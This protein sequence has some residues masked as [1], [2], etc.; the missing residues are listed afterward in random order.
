MLLKLIY[1]GFIIIIIIIFQVKRNE[2]F[3]KILRFKFQ[4]TKYKKI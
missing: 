4:Y 3:L 1:N 2:Y